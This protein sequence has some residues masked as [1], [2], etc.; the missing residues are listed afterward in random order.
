M[1][2]YSTSAHNRH[3]IRYENNSQG[4]GCAND[5]ATDAP[6]SSAL[7]SNTATTSHSSPG[8]MTESSST[9]ETSAPESPDAGTSDRDRNPSSRNVTVSRPRP[10]SRKSKAGNPHTVTPSAAGPEGG[11]ICKF[12]E[13]GKVCGK[14]FKL[15][16]D[17]R[18]VTNI[19]LDLSEEKF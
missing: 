6:Y 1:S 17:I 2:S 7:S 10:F 13:R 11:F 4:L 16:S 19:D 3:E 5:N 14:T 8:E 18:F 12:L 15:P 9:I